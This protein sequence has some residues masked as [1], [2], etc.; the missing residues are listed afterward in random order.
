MNLELKTSVV[1]ERMQLR[2][3]EMGTKV[4]VRTCKDDIIMTKT[5]MDKYY[6]E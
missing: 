1:R 4:I 2:P 5:Q 3:C 6:R